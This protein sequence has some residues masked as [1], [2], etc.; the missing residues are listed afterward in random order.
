MR[1]NIQAERA[2]FVGALAMSLCFGVAAHGASIVLGD[3]SLKPNMPGQTISIY[4]SGGEAVGGVGLEV[5]TGDGGADAGGSVAAPKISNVSFLTPGSVFADNN[6]GYLENTA[7]SAINSAATESQFWQAVTTTASGTVNL[8]TASTAQLLA[9]VTIDT[10][11]FTGGSY[12]LVLDN[13]ASPTN[14]PTVGLNGPTTPTIVDGILTI[15][16]SGAHTTPAPEPA[17][18]A[19]LGLAAAGLMT[20]RRRCIG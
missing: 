19:M 20:R 10:T 6:A 14:F 9:V 8:G 5:F 12:P 13:P 17:S 7:T 15:T 2:W 3:Y 4:V 18:I 11:G 16:G 1:R